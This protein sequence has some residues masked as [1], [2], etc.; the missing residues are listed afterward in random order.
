MTSSGRSGAG[1]DNDTYDPSQWGM[2]KLAGQDGYDA[3]DG[4]MMPQQPQLWSQQPPT[5]QR[6]P[7]GSHQY[8]RPRRRDSS[9]STETGDDD[10]DYNERTGRRR[11]SGAGALQRRHRSYDG[12]RDEDDEDGRGRGREAGG[13]V[14]RSMSRLRTTAKDLLGGEDGEDGRENTEAKK[15]A[16]TVAG[17]VVGGWRGGRRARTTGCRRLLGL[18]WGA[19]RRG[20]W[21]RRIIAGRTRSGRRRRMGG[22][23]EGSRPRSRG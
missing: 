18:S 4:Y 11:A 14:R 9:L 13:L 2:R 6:S 5:D 7:R 17:A 12:R 19:L 22:G 21:R 20:S 8:Q 3:G 15:W 1:V 10:D 16:V 23:G